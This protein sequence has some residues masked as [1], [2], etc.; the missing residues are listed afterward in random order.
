MEQ[1]QCCISQNSMVTNAWGSVITEHHG[2]LVQSQQRID[3]QIHETN[4]SFIKKKSTVPGATYSFHK[5]VAFHRHVRDDKNATRKVVHFV[6]DRKCRSN[7]SVLV[8]T[9]GLYYNAE[10]FHSSLWIG[11]LFLD[12]TWKSSVNQ[13]L[14]NI[15]CIII[16]PFSFL[17]RKLA[18]KVWKLCE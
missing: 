16:S 18:K 17:M 10:T 14:S 7:S 9:V 4:E 2:K 8:R 1:R 5:A 12:L 3:R 15:P 6:T 13:R 11:K